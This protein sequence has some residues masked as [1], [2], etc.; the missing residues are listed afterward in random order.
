MKR[1]ALA[2]GIGSGKSA[3]ETH[4]R[5]R[6]FTVIDAD[7]VARR[8]VEPGE[9]AWRA[10]VDAFGSAVLTADGAIDRAF[11]ADVV[12]H[13]PS[14][15]RRL[16]GIT[17]GYIGAEILRRLEAATGPAAFVALPLYRPEHRAVFELDEVWVLSTELDTVLARLCADRGFTEED[18]RA[19]LSNQPPLASLVAMADRVI[20]NNGTLDELFAELDGALVASGIVRG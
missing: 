7:E 9:P 11:V 17:H 12:F 10:L 15:L 14:A 1:I 19:R 6:G 20:R 18:A 8:V 2:G 13:D 4:L 3:A 16:N 5:D